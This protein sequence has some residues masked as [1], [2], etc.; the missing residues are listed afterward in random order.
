MN[1]VLSTKYDETFTMNFIGTEYFEYLVDD[2]SSLKLVIDNPI[3]GVT[4][5]N[6]IDYRIDGVVDE[7]QYL[8]IFFKY[9]NEL[10]NNVPCDECWSDMLDIDMLSGLTLNPN[11]P[12]EFE[13][14]IYRVDDVSDNELPTDLWVSN[15]IIYGEYLIERTDGISTIT[16]DNNNIILSPNDVYKVFSVDDFEII[17]RGD[18]DNIDVK[19]RVT[20]NNGRSYSEWE[21]LTKENISTFRFNELRFVMMEYLITQVYE[22]DIPTIIYDIILHGDFQNVSANYLKNNKYGLREDCLTEYINSETGSTISCGIPQ[23]T[24]KKSDDDKKGNDYDLKMNFHTQGLSCYVTSN[25]IKEVERENTSNV[26]NM[27]N[28]Y[29]TDKITDLANKLANDVNDVFSW[30]VDYHLTDPDEGGTDMQLHEY[31]LFNIVDVK[32][33]RIIIPENKFPDNII[34]MTKLNLDLLD[35][36]E[37]HILK[38]EFKMSFG[39]DKRPAENDI[40]FLCDMN[41]LYRVKHAQVF[42]EIMYSGTFWKVILEKYEQKTNIRN[43][44]NESKTKLDSLTK[45]TTMD[46]LFGVEKKEEENKIA[47]KSQTK[48]IT[49]EVIRHT[50][51][52]DVIINNEQLYN[53]NID[54]SKYHYD[55]WK[56][57]GKKVV[58]YQI[59]DNLNKGENRSFITW[60]NFNNRYNEDDTIN[61]KNAHLY[62]YIDNK[63]NFNLLNNYDE[64]NKLGYRYWYHKNRIIFQINE[65]YYQLDVKLLTNIWY[66]LV[67]NLNQRLGEL[68]MSVYK[69]P[70]EHNIKMMN[71]TTYETATVKSDDTNGYEYL[72]NIGYKPVDN[73]EIHNIS[74]DF[75]LVCSKNIKINTFEF[76]IDNKNIEIIGSDIKYTNLRV[77]KEVIPSKNI[78]N[79][80]NQLVIVDEHHLILG[81]NANRRIYADNFLV[82]K[83]D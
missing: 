26:D 1:Y 7:T 40:I 82:K 58:T 56:S 81:D 48:P 6:N 47:N 5:L 13:L 74:T 2:G 33:M 67:I 16:K 54:F 73:Q 27:W 18:I 71:P 78:N 3:S 76:S 66:G 9:K 35:T 79:I 57:L 38:D 12:F 30:K 65:S 10:I 77:F 68:S 46:D 21:S 62:Y 64:N 36:F 72:L 59:N 45:N 50:I 60:F 37:I 42:R 11:Y 19:Y 14:Y 17:S 8:K 43:L 53:G 34:R 39:I 55:F 69:R 25:T 61:N 15:I 28:P 31:Q 24:D 80:L 63:I 32:K 51:Y 70:G 22:S 83:W 29:E 41:R 23:Y 44:S 4:K 49:N 20:Q 52:K 75:E